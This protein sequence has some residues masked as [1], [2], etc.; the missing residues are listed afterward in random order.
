MWALYWNTS[1]SSSEPRLDPDIPW[2]LTTGYNSCLRGFDTLFWLP[3][4][5]H[6][7]DPQTYTQV[8]YLHTL[9][10]KRLCW[11]GVEQAFLCGRGCPGACST[12]QTGLQLSICLPLPP[13][14]WDQRCV[15]LPLGGFFFLKVVASSSVSVEMG[16]GTPKAWPNSET[17][18]LKELMN[19]SL[20]SHPPICI[21]LCL[22]HKSLKS[23]L[24][25]RLERNAVTH[26]ILAAQRHCA[27]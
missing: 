17:V 10:T 25:A 1:C 6:T 26:S 20:G 14:C 11:V 15:P 9:K 24:T 27:E 16:M 21:S 8:Q 12:D 7:H 18:D 2:Q 3:W 13:R 5:L 22:R 4:T 23:L 19:L